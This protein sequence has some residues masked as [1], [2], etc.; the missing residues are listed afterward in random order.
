MNGWEL[1]GITTWQSGFPFTVFSGADNSLSGIG[2]DRAEVTGSSIGQAVLSGQ[3]TAQEIKQYFNT[4]LFTAN[5]IGTY[6]NSPKNALQGPDL[7]NQ[8]FAAIKNFNLIEAM[9]LQFRAEF[10]NVFNNV[11]FSKPGSSVNSASFGQIT[12]A[13]SPRILQFALKVMF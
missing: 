10:F 1:T 2:A 13:A 11:N 4:S 8:D 12:S 7:F 9:K 6:G 3:S 5:P